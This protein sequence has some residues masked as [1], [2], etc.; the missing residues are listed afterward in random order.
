MLSPLA[1]RSRAAQRARPEEPSSVRLE[2]QRD[3]DRIIHTKSFRRL[4]H[5]TQVFI[6]PAG[7]HYRTRLTH[8]LE[9]TQ[10]ARTIA[11]ALRLNEDLVEAIGLAHD[12]GHTPF[13]HAGEV[14]LAEVFPGFRH[15]EQSLRVVDNLEKDGAG[16]N[17]TD[18]VRDGILRHSKPRS[19][20]TGSLSGAPGSLE[21]EVVKIADGVAYINHDLDDALRAGIVQ[22]VDVPLEVVEVLGNSHA[23][24]IDTLVCD[25]IEQSETVKPPG[26]ITM[27]D[28]VRIAADRLRDFLFD[29]VYTPL[30]E[31]PDTLRAQELVRT[32]FAH[33][34][35]D[36]DRIP[37]DYCASG[38]QDT[39]DRRAADFVSSMTDRHAVETFQELF[40]PRFWSV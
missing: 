16:L 22:P 30:N 28:Q 12:L 11:R 33:F 24:R 39:P 8:T 18:A 35:D 19:G 26:R 4:K 1:R 5:K 10:I 34:R 13:G 15:N 31:R 6:A 9:V 20:I 7:D 36:V 32:L 29:R 3:R 21:G 25:I 37:R 17:L 27:S 40:V 2:F 23:S 38:P 14:A